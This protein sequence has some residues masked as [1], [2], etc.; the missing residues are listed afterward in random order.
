MEYG[1]PIELHEIHSEKTTTLVDYFMFE[2]DELHRERGYY[3]PH[4]KEN[5]PPRVL[6]KTLLKPLNTFN[7]PLK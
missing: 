5:I 3:T 4:Q 1:N 6:F 7:F 2:H